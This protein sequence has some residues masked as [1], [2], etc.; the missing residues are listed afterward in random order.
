MWH[1][2]DCCLSM[3]CTTRQSFP[4]WA[5][6]LGAGQVTHTSTQ[7]AYTSENQAEMKATVSKTAYVREETWK[8]EF[9][10]R[11][12][13]SHFVFMCYITRVS[14]LHLNYKHCSQLD[15]RRYA[16]EHLIKCVKLRVY[17]KLCSIITWVLC[18]EYSCI[19][20]WCSY[21]AS[22]NAHANLDNP[23]SATLSKKY[24]GGLAQD[25]LSMGFQ[26][27]LPFFIVL[28]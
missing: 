20:R 19:S 26:A 10:K 27:N 7:E 4:M 11:L 17:W 25:G 3:D 14:N 13:E 21:T 5:V 2:A 23:H 9:S 8:Q 18:L 1:D 22:P 28:P 12:E 15:W 6:R 24:P 16:P